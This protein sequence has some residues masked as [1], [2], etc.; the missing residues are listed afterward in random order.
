MR[1]S[2]EVGED[3]NTSWDFWTLQTDIQDE[4]S[5]LEERDDAVDRMRWLA[6]C[7]DV[8]AQYFMGKLYMDG[9]LVIPDSEIAAE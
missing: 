3:E 1:Q 7:G 6:E 8:H 4:S 9:S 2:D 5:P